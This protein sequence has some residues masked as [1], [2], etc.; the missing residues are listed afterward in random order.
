MKNEAWVNKYAP[1]CVEDM[2]LDDSTKK[3][4]TNIVE[5]GD[6][7]NLLLVGSPGIG[8]TTLAKIIGKAL[9]ANVLVQNCS[10][11]GSID[12]VKSSVTEFCEV[13]LDKKRKI[14]SLDEADQMSQ[15]A[16]MALRNPIS[17]YSGVDKQISFI[18]TANYI[19]KIIPAIQSRCICI[20]PTYTDKDIAKRVVD[21]LKTENIS[22]TKSDIQKFLTEV[23]KAKPNR[24]IRSIIENLQ[25]MSIDGK[26]SVSSI[27]DNSGI[28]EIVDYILGNLKTKRIREI[29]KYL[30]QNEE[31]FHN[32]YPAL[33]QALFDRLIESDCKDSILISIAFA[34]QRMS[35]Q[36]YKEIQ[37]IWMLLE[38]RNDL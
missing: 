18:L 21:I 4:F 25:L 24:D 23:V 38:I 8:K 1:T 9:D 11:D 33:A 27:K 26:L 7:N 14:V 5:K 16:Q 20:S 30:M 3:V 31:V 36:I 17:N 37:F 6:M 22:F 32:D 35:N 12:V 2:I 10:I 13:I 34:M 15:Q 29:R 19:D 28:S